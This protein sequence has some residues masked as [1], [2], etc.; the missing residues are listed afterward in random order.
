MPCH[1]AIQIAATAATAAGSSARISVGVELV[2]DAE[3]TRRAGA[4]RA[5]AAR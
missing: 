2:D 4:R 1:E 5:G 3:R